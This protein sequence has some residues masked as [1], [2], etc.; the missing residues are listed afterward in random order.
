MGGNSVPDVPAVDVQTESITKLLQDLVKIHIELYICIQARQHLN[1]FLK[2]TSLQIP[3]LLTFI[4]LMHLLS[5]VNHLVNG[6]LP[7]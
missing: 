7:M 1:Q 3:L 2:Q 5:R 4:Y 6:N